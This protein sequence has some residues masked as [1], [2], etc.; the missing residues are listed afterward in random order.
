MRRT[1]PTGSRC[2]PVLSTITSVTNVESTCAGFVITSYSIHY[3]KL[4]DA[5]SDGPATSQDR[6]NLGP[7]S[8][9]VT[10]TDAHG[11]TA[12][13]GATITQPDLL[14]ASQQHVNITCY[15]DADGSIDVSVVGRITSYN[16]CYTKLLRS[17]SRMRITAV[18]L[19]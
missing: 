10:V 6:S 11:C 14:V 15:G 12:Q 4:Y 17:L 18:Q 2:V 5:W 19:V 13:T 3:T 1:G 16:V 9:T 8:Y 7:G